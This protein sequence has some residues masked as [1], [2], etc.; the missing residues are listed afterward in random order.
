[1][2]R[3]LNMVLFMT[4]VIAATLHGSCAQTT[5][6]V[7]DSM[8][9]I[10]P[11]GGDAAYQTWAAINTFRVGDVLV[12]NFSTGAHD[13]AEVTR[14][15]FDSCNSAS[16]ITISNTGPTSINLTSAVEHN[17]ICTVGRHCSFGQR[18]S[19][20]VSSSATAPSPQPTPPPQPAAATPGPS[21]A[22]TPPPAAAPQPA[23][24]TPGPMAAVPA[25]TPPPA[26][27]PSPSEAGNTYTVG[28]SIGWIVPPGGSI[29]YETWARTIRSF[30]VGD[31]LLFN[32]TTGA[33][34]VVEVTRAEFDSCRTNTAPI[35]TG[36][37]RITLTSAGEHHYIC[38]VGPHCSLGQRLAI[39]V[40][41]GAGGPTMTPPPSS[42][43]PVT[44]SP[45]TA[46]PPPSSSA[47]SFAVAGLPF[48]FLTI[49]MA[50]LV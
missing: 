15:N 19:I 26:A 13:V 18:L 45:V 14:T 30:R 49:V 16:P 4:L 36:P 8:G 46:P 2:E 41:G 21:A 37:A 48:T 50:F 42:S 27:A 28:G 40:T 32:F 33:H 20:N 11:P 25:A 1:M 5:H 22:A 12:F 24:A 44:P 10:V 31:T 38:T 9:W 29:A 43:T 7:G 3:G 6:V 47:S 23:A 34:D 35:T 39:N 17:F